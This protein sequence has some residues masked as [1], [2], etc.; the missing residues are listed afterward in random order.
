MASSGIPVLDK[1]LGG[2][3]YP[4]KSTVLV[5]GPPGVGKE[6]LGYW[7]MYSG[8]VQ[9][10]FSLYVTR[11]SAQDV[12]HDTK[13][14]GVDLSQ[15]IP[16]WLSSEGGEAKFDVNDLASLS[17]NIKEILKKNS[18]RRIRI[19]VDALSSLLMLNPPE[20]IY[21]FLSQL[22]IEVKQYDA[23][24][25]GTLEEGMHRPDIL[26]AMQQ[27][28][29][30]FIEMSFYRTGLNVIPLFRVG[31]MRGVAPQPDY[32]R[33]RFAQGSLIIEGTSAEAVAATTG[34]SGP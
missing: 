31:K 28:F 9:N 26:T 11:L 16:F 19:V 4:D 29:D 12:I 3:G 27:L 30:G 15:R 33:F 17:F 14:F 32:F 18:G 10:D 22:F 20:T 24:L 25:L 34:G 13:A 21:K 2:E 1:M 6:A 7:F 5:V 8:L 23:V